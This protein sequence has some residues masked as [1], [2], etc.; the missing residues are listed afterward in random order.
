[1]DVL[2]HS[3]CFFPIFFNLKQ[4][5]NQSTSAMSYLEPLWV[6]NWSRL[7]RR[8]MRTSSETLKMSSKA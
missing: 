3:L 6:Y 2:Q 5:L 1:M 8:D 7:R 4:K